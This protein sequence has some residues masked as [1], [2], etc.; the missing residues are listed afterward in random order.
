MK[1]KHDMRTLLGRMRSGNASFG[2]DLSKVNEKKKQ[3]TTRELLGRLRKLN[4][5]VGNDEKERNQKNMATDFDKKYWV[6]K[7]NNF[8][9]DLNV[10]LTPEDVMELEVFDDYVFW[11]ATVLGEIQFLY[12]VTDED[13]T[14]GVQFNYAKDFNAEN[15]ENKKLVDRIRIFYDQFSDYWRKNRQ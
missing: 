9:D 8:F 13:S 7:F 14:S 10:T 6:S 11:G 12:S 2:N 1:D 3:P 5:E 15:E 4:E